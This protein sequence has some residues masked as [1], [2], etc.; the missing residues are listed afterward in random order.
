MA[1]N[2]LLTPVATLVEGREP[3]GFLRKPKHPPALERPVTLDLSS[4]FLIGLLLVGALACGAPKDRQTLQSKREAE[5]DRL[6]VQRGMPEAWQGRS[7]RIAWANPSETA[8]TP[9][10]LIVEVK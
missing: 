5:L 1:L 3:Q 9:P 6:E 10:V 7:T 4:R 8:P 2:L